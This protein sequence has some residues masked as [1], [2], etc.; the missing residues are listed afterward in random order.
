MSAVADCAA[1]RHSG[2]SAFSIRSGTSPKDPARRKRFSY[3][4]FGLAASIALLLNRRERRNGHGFLRFQL[5]RFLGFTIAV[6][7]TS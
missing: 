2:Q 5:F 1:R 3:F 4:F 6:F 7:V